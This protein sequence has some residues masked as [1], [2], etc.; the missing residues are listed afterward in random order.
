ML[1]VFFFLFPCPSEPTMKG[2]ISA[3]IR[4]SKVRQTFNLKN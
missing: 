4:L 1:Y 2:V 3:K